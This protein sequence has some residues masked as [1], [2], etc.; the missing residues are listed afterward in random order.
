MC[1]SYSKE[2]DPVQWVHYIYC[3]YGDI[4]VCTVYTVQTTVSLTF[5]V[6]IQVLYR[7]QKSVQVYTTN[8]VL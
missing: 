7:L 3:I 5:K 1:L 8:T 4:R 2:N 6:Q